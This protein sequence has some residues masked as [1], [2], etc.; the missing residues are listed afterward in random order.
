MRFL[1]LLLAVMAA[2]CLKTSVPRQVV[3]E[4]DPSI[5]FPEF[6][7][8]PAQRVGQQGSLH[9]LDGVTLRALLIAANDFLP[10]SLG[11]G[12]CWEQQS[13]YLY[14]V[15]RRSDVVFIRIDVDPASCEQG[16]RLLDLGVRYAISVDGR[17][18]RRLYD[19]E[20]EEIPTG[21]S[22]D[23]GE[24]ADAGE[25]APPPPV[26]ATWGEPSPFI[27]PSWLDGGIAADAGSSVR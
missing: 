21:S 17:I 18:L 9:E 6:F 15:I 26:G 12:H 25:A 22:F 11:K 8:Q 4:E 1:V 14:R 3:S 7:E 20:P 13:A 27:P 19:G 10:E 5:T 24:P 2:S 23:A 16:L